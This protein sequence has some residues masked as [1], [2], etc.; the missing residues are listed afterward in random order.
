MDRKDFIIA[1]RL[2]DSKNASVWCDLCFRDIEYHDRYGLNC[3]GLA[4]NVQRCIEFDNRKHIAVIT[5][6]ECRHTRCNH[7]C[8]DCMINR[9]LHPRIIL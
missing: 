8:S 5:K 1:F 7:V 6:K 9:T 4:C 3:Y 2:K